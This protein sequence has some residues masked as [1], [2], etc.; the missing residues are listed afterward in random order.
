MWWR[1]FRVN[2]ELMI[3]FYLSLRRVFLVSFHLRTSLAISLIIVRGTPA[4][5]RIATELYWSASCGIGSYQKAQ[6]GNTLKSL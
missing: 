2:I 3:I 4:L 1:H 5:F 6:H